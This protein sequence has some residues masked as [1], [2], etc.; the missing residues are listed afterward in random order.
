MAEAELAQ[1]NA[2]GARAAVVKALDAMRRM[3]EGLSPL[4]AAL[5]SEVLGRN[6][7]SA[8]AKDVAFAQSAPSDMFD[9][10]ERARAGT[11]AS[12]GEEE[13]PPT[14]TAEQ[15]K[16][17]RA[18]QEQA[19]AARQRCEEAS[20]GGNRAE[21]NRLLGEYAIAR[22]ACEGLKEAMLAGVSPGGDVLT[23]DAFR[24]GLRGSDALVVYAF[25]GGRLRALLVT[26]AGAKAVDLC[27]EREA[28][29]AVK[30]VRSAIA[31]GGGTTDE[32]APGQRLV[33]PLGLPPGVRR[34]LISPDGALTLLPWAVLLPEHEVVLVPSATAL[35]ALRPPREERGRRVLALA[36]LPKINTVFL[37]SVIFYT[38]FFLAC[39]HLMKAM[40]DRNL[41]SF[42]RWC[43]WRKPLGGW[44]QRF[45]R[46]CRYVPP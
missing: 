41:H 11:L 7:L 5:S 14:A 6:H 23:L 30:A 22:R 3:S 40:N 36:I 33:A 24:S 45:V 37:R 42:M 4:R 1:G 19:L 26:T 38:L 8:V 34:V 44:T 13:A 20:G 17:L 43:A 29:S 39:V 10:L 9:L 16:E 27:S 25:A 12:V 2:A 15:L 32:L 46:I 31:S 21:L 35:C 28:D 18:A